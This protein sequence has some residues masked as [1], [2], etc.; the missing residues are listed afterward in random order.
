MRHIKDEH[1]KVL[2]FQKKVVSHLGHNRRTKQHEAKNSADLLLRRNSVTWSSIWSA[3]SNTNILMF[4]VSKT[5]LVTQ[6]LRVPG[7]PIMTWSTI[8]SRRMDENWWLAL[9]AVA[10]HA[11]VIPVNFAIRVATSSFWDHSKQKYQLHVFHICMII[12]TL[13]CWSTYYR[14]KTT[15]YLSGCHCTLQYGQGL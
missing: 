15:E 11:I 3:S 1:K 9:S 14:D 8:F 10:V 13:G 7:V 2:I 5:L 12:C 4:F 6:R